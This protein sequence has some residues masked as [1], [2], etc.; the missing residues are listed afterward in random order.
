M[1]AII[2]NSENQLR[3][4]LRIILLICFLSNI[5]IIITSI[6]S[7]IVSIKIYNAEGIFD[8]TAL[9]RGLGYLIFHLSTFYY[10]MLPIKGCI[11]TFIL[12]ILSLLLLNGSIK[13]WKLIVT[14]VI[15]LITDI[16]KVAFIIGLIFFILLSIDI[17]SLKLFFAFLVLM[18]SYIILL[19]LNIKLI[20]KPIHKTLKEIKLN[21]N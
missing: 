5:L 20:H 11:I 9:I 6:Y 21:A 18:I 8:G 13:R 3:K 15:V 19:I 10:G 17:A 16:I 4:N 2:N 1:D 7:I 14:N 12:L